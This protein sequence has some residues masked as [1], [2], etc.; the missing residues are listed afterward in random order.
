MATPKTISINDVEMGILFL[1]PLENGIL[2]IRRDYT[3][4][5]SDQELL[6]AAGTFTLTRSAD[7][8]TLPTD[9]KNA[10]QFL[11]NYSYNEALDERGIGD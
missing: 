5:G 9:L 4:V 10:I 2:T 3:L 8:G 7:W 1:Y 6:D 11:N